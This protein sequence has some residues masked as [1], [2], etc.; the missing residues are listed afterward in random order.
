MADAGDAVVQRLLSEAQRL[1]PAAPPVAIT[2]A[3]KVSRPYS[4]VYR[5]HLANRVEAS[6]AQRPA[7]L[8]AKIFRPSAHNLHNQ[9]KYLDRLQIEFEIAEQLHAALQGQSHF[10]VVRPV[11]YYPELL[12][13]VTE[14][15]QGRVLAEIV[16]EA[17]KH[18]S[19]RNALERAV[20]HCRRAG[21]ALAA[22][23]AATRVAGSFDCNELFEYIKIRLQ[24]LLES[25]AAPFSAADHKLVLN[26]L[27]RALTNI[28]TD[29]LAQCGCHC[30]YAPFNVLADDER[31]TVLDFSMFKIGSCYNDATY[32]HH[33]LEGYLHKPIFS[34]SAIQAAQRAFLEGYNYA[35]ARA[36]H[37]IENDLLF[38]VLWT[39]HV[40]NN[41]SAIMRNRVGRGLRLPSATRMFNRHIFRRYNNWLMRMC[42]V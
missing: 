29:Q 21:Q 1:W 3:Q 35:C 34:A 26:F 31:V 15:A 9:Q 7:V 4:T 6:A 2:I 32:F 36:N 16:A 13:L 22:M 25:E 42:R 28:P 18:W 23:Q 8:Y 12:A 20:L 33:R 30:D 38:R 24:R 14:E 5:L 37:P 11:V 17:C 39:K 41:Y 19:L 27:E 10:G 40:I